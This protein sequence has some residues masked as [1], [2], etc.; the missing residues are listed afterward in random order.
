MSEA[1]AFLASV[2]AGIIANIVTFALLQRF[3]KPTAIRVEH[4]RSH[5]TITI[6]RARRT[7]VP[8]EEESTS[9]VVI[10]RWHFV[11]ENRTPRHVGV[12]LAVGAIGLLVTLAVVLL[13]S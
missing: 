4:H 8:L 9:Q 5:M 3:D 10:D 1:G 13:L 7:G 12:S 2:A 6:T 11:L